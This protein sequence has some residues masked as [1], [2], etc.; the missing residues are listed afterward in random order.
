MRKESPHWRHKIG[1]GNVAHRVIADKLRSQIL[2]GSLAPGTELPSTTKLAAIWKTSKSTAH[3]ALS[4]LVKE[5]LLERNHGSATHV[6][7]RPHKLERV[8]IYYDSPCVWTDEERVFIRSI[9][10]QL[11]AKL[12]EQGIKISV[13]VDRRPEASQR[14][15]LPELSKAVAYRQIQGLI[16]P[17]VNGFNLP[18]LM[19]LSLPLSIL[20]G[21]PDVGSR[22]VIDDKRIFADIFQRLAQ[23]KCRSVGLISSLQTRPDLSGS[24]YELCFTA[25][26][27]EEAKRHRMRTRD[28]WI[29]VPR[30]YVL[31]KGIYGFKEFHNL[32]SLPEHPEAV[33][34]YPDMVVRGVITAALQLGAHRSE[35]VTFCFHRNAHVEVLC[36]FP[37]LWSI[38]DEAKIADALIDLVRCQYEG[39]PVSP[40]LVPSAFEE[41]PSTV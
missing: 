15:V 5:G 12:A 18:G 1:Q 28:E 27:L 10:R 2:I 21:S 4:N 19:E 9:Q 34:V 29:R 23:K 37:A 25:H 13:F 36:P 41:S 14:P 8:G 39:K 33:L 26:F 20:T 16:I 32:W 24:S 6:S 3:T 38:T 35:K 11:E 17:T 40:A 30:E 31:E 7:H 22:M